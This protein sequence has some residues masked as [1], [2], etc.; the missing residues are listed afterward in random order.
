MVAGKRGKGKT[1][2]TVDSSLRDKGYRLGDKI[3][4]NGSAR[5]YKIVAL[6]I[7]PRSTS[8]QLFMAPLPPGESYGW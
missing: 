8:L 2:I 4:L 6:L 7:T 3:S 5:K 1:E